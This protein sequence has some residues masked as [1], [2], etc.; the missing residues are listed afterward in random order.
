VDK[1]AEKE[2]MDRFEAD[3]KR[4]CALKGEVERLRGELV[5]VGMKAED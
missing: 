3:Q 4:V 1:V 5:K 2:L